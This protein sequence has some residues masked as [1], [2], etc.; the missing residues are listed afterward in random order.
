MLSKSQSRFRV[1]E[2]WACQGIAVKF[3]VL[4]EKQRG[5][6]ICKFR[7]R[8]FRSAF[9]PLLPFTPTLRSCLSGYF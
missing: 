1:F 5:L 4:K 8:G 7:V 2:C 3:R 6:V 9:S